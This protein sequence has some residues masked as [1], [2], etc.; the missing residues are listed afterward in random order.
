MDGTYIYLGLIPPE[1]SAGPFFYK[2]NKAG[3]VGYR[4]NAE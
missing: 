4:V 3:M 2:M 1:W